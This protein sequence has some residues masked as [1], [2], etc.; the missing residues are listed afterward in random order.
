[1]DMKLITMRAPRPG[2]TAVALVVALALALALALV[3]LP[4]SE[5]LAATVQLP[6]RPAPPK[7]MNDLAGM[8]SGASAQSIENKLVDLWQRS[9]VQM[10]VVTV[11]TIEGWTIEEFAVEL[12]ELWGIGEAGKDNGLL[13][14]FAEE[15]REV[16]FE[17][18]YGLE[19][20]LPDSFLGRVIDEA[21]VP[22]MRASDV[23]GAIDA[24]I[25]MVQ[26]RLEGWE[27]QGPGD[28][29]EWRERVAEVAAFIAFLIIAVV[30]IAASRKKPRGPGSGPKSGGGY[31]GPYVPTHI[32]TIRVGGRGRGG[33]SGGGGGEGFGGF[34][35]GRSGGGGASGKW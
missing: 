27:G 8:L 18:G 29:E 1:M 13:L 7:L 9:G 10:A 14:L 33:W 25:S 31:R 6:A 26:S 35:G 12:F 2:L 15:Q 17:T 5:A 22:S 11:D 21:I 3:W 23:A 32:P 28:D 34:G 16:R 4:G 20:D 24:A 30:I 19:G